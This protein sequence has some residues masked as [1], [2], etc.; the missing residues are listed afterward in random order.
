MAWQGQQAEDRDR[1]DQDIEAGVR[2]LHHQRQ[3]EHPEP[4]AR[5]AARGTAAAGPQ[6][7]G[8]GQGIGDE[9]ED[10]ERLQIAQE[11]QQLRGDHDEAGAGRILPGDVADGIAAVGQQVAPVAIQRVHLAGDVTAPLAQE[12]EHDHPAGDPVG[13]E[14]EPLLRPGA[15]PQQYRACFR[16]TATEAVRVRIGLIST[17]AFATVAS[18]FHKSA[19]PEGKRGDSPCRLPSSATARGHR[20]SVTSDRF[21]VAPYYRRVASLPTGK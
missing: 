12:G 4:G 15:G 11:G 17:G 21:G 19:M 9:D 5:Q 16:A 13:D 6:Q 7:G 20:T 14:A 1:G 10:D 3:P 8:R 2:Q 18:A